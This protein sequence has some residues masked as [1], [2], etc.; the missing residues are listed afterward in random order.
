MATLDRCPLCGEDT[1][2]QLSWQL[3]FGMK[4]NLPCCETCRNQLLPIVGPLCLK[5]GRSLQQIDSR[6]VEGKQC[7]DCV[8]WGERG[9]GEVL[10]HNK[11][12]FEY[13]DFLKKILALYKFRGD[14]EVGRVF[15]SLILREL[16]GSYSFIDQVIPMP[17]S[18]ERMY[19]RGFNQC[20][21]WIE[22]TRFVQD[23][24]LMRT[25]NEEKQSKR[26]RE[27]RINREE[28]MFQI[29][30]GANV[31][32]KKLLL[33]DDIYTTGTTIHYAAFTLKNAGAS[34]VYSLTLS[35]G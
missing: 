20:E 1:S 35:R 5:C 21:V 27:K 23:S 29:V 31:V 32:G 2:N 12:S 18:Q 6:F 30:E 10:T 15:S 24:P 17:A 13:N 33:L 9:W 4:N 3:L 14:V 34:N 22:G 11:S 8:R 19:E 7:S 25:K 26:T 16:K 28:E